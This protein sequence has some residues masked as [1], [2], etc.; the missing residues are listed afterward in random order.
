REDHELLDEHVR[1]RLL[2]APGSRD[3]SARVELELDLGRLDAQ[4]SAREPPLAE[5]GRDRFRPSQRLRQVGVN[6]L[7]AGE[8]LLGAPVGEPLAAADDGAVEAGL[9]A[10]ERELDRDAQAILA[11]S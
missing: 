6:T 4:G 1:V 11:G 10:L 9:A 8:D 2:G 5:V 7:A 3:A